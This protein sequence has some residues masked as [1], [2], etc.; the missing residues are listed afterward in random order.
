[1]KFTI[2]VEGTRSEI[3]GQ[4]LDAVALFNG[5]GKEAE[6]PAAAPAAEKKSKKA[7][8]VEEPAV[9]E[10]D[11]GDFDLGEEESEDA[12]EEEDAAPKIT[13]EEVIGGFK[14][15]AKKKGRDKAAAI[16]GKFKVKSVRDLKS[17]QY[18]EVLK[19]LGIKK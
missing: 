1:M 5:N 2:H 4:L 16:L 17:E 19:A 11:E 13:L 9:V 15:Y 7:A 14:E 12:G 18:A 6:A 10:E 8:K 3:A